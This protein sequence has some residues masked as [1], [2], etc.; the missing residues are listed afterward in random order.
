MALW[1]LD[2][3]FA[4]HMN[5]RVWLRHDTKKI[6]S[7]IKKK[8]WINIGIMFDALERNKSIATSKALWQKQNKRTVVVAASIIQNKCWSMLYKHLFFMRSLTGKMMMSL[9]LHKFL[10]KILHLFLILYFYFFFIRGKN[11]YIKGKW[12]KIIT[13]MRSIDEP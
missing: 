3:V 10:D 4:E 8:L 7:L 9:S 12:K 2:G 6:H 1:R 5:F 11:F 13:F